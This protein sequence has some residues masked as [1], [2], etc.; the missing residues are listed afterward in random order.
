MWRLAALA[1]MLCAGCR[2]ELCQQDTRTF[3]GP[4]SSTAPS[5]LPGQDESV[6]PQHPR[7]QP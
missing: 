6:S 7:A 2:E 5:T 4:Y 1:L 3:F